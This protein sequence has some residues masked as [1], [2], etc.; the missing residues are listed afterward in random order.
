M[1]HYAT[2]LQQAIGNTATEKLLQQWEGTRYRPS[3][4]TNELYKLFTDA[5]LEYADRASPTTKERNEETVQH[6]ITW[7]FFQPAD[8]SIFDNVN[9]YNHLHLFH[10][11]K[12]RMKRYRIADGSFVT[13]K[14]YKREYEKPTEKEPTTKEGKRANNEAKLQESFRSRCRLTRHKAAL[15]TLLHKRQFLK[16]IDN[17]LSILIAKETALES[18]DYRK[19]Q[20]YEYRTMRL[21]AIGQGIPVLSSEEARNAKSKKRQ[22]KLDRDAI[23]CLADTWLCPSFAE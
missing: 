23:T 19:Q 15:L 6:W 13:P 17:P 11:L 4:L 7:L 20:A 21:H 10:A 5:L 8:G 22:K 2:K 18:G 3:D 12:Y 14:D 1:K 16:N 9:R